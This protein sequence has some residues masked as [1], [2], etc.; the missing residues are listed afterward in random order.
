MLTDKENNWIRLSDSPNRHILVLGSSGQGKTFFCCQ[1]MEEELERGRNVLVYDFS[2]SYREK[3]LE[4]AQFKY[5][6]K[7]EMLN[8]YGEQ[9]YFPVKMASV[10]RFLKSILDVLVNAF[11]IRSYWQKKVL[12]QAIKVHMKS[13]S[14]F[15]FAEFFCTVERLYVQKREEEGTSDERDSFLKI[16]TRL[17]PYSDI[18]NVN[19]EYRD[20]VNRKNG[21]TIIQLSDFPEHQRQFLTEIFIGMLWEEI[22][23]DGNVGYD[24]VV[25]DEF[26]H[27]SMS[28]YGALPKLL[29]Q[30]RKN[31]ISLIL[32]S[33]FIR[34]YTPEEQDLLLLAGNILLFKPTVKDRVSCADIVDRNNLKYWLSVLDSL[35]VGEAVLAGNYSINNSLEVWQK[36]IVCKIEKKVMKNVGRTRTPKPY[37]SAKCKPM[38]RIKRH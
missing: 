2:S 32:L 10:D 18:E 33:Q 20:E 4:K 21:M 34:N 7:V 28:K 26:Q 8:P 1:R 11:N 15:N 38:P 25:L 35:Q 14:A 23:A 19:F 37:M 27:L 12:L 5:G 17:E 30:S 29:R 9:N 31:G 6:E 22:M 24:T 3:E 36:P 13:H 16:L